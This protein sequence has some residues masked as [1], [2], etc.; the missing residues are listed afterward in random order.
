ML[1]F[2]LRNLTTLILLLISVCTVSAFATPTAVDPSLISKLE[3]SDYQTQFDVVVLLHPLPD[4]K[5]LENL[6][7]GVERNQ[8]SSIVWN[9]LIEQTS[10]SQ[11]GFN[12]ALSG[13]ATSA[14]IPLAK[15]IYICNGVQLQVSKAELL[16]I[17]TMDVVRVCIDD[18]PR[19]IENESPTTTDF[20]EDE[21]DDISWHISHIQAPFIW[22][23]GY[24]GQGVLVAVFD[25]GVN[26]NHLD[27]RDHVWDGG[28]EYPNHGY[29]FYD[30][31][32][33]PMDSAGHGTAAA[34]IVAGDGSAGTTTGVA[35]DATIM[36][37]KV[38][39]SLNVG[40]VGDTWRA[41]DFVVEHGVDIVQMSLGWGDPGL[42]DRP[43]WRHNYNVLNAA[44]IVNVKS[45][46]NRRG[47]RE[48]PDAISVP[49]GVPSPWRHPDEIEAGERSGLITVGSLNQENN[50][51]ASSSPG[52]VT[53][54]DVEGYQDFLLGDGH[55]G[56]IKPDLAAPGA[57]GTSLRHSNDSLYGGFSHTS[58]AAPHV[59]GVV[60][61]MLSKDPNLLPVQVDSLL[62]CSAQDLGEPGKD[63]DYGAG[64]V[65]ADLAVDAIDV[66]MGRVKGHVSGNFNEPVQ[67]VTV[68]ALERPR[69]HNHT[70][71]TGYFEF[72]LQPGE[73]TI[74]VRF[75]QFELQRQ[76]SVQIVEN[77]TTVID[78]VI[79]TLDVPQINTPTQ[80]I[81]EE[82]AIRSV[83]PNP[84]NSTVTIQYEIPETATISMQLYSIEGRLVDTL[85][86]SE[87]HIAGKYSI[88][89]ENSSL[90]SGIYLLIM[91]T[92]SGQKMSQ[93]LLYLK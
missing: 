70:D 1:N 57:N 38:R 79:N 44:G 13:I 71:S 46:G 25:T 80:L 41:Q 68:M 14:T 47:V 3:N 42:Y 29:N 59:S 23:D 84:F 54:Q 55:V 91:S 9:T 43:V 30:D 49:G 62:Q 48:P 39:R 8:R 63:N 31:S 16:E 50:F 4:V 7:K 92:D 89:Y 51:L 18:S 10:N 73:Y 19:T 75:Q 87:L 90:S 88:N 81:P 77:D 32:F 76:D 86:S 72:D 11:T 35:P 61:L 85:E 34:G 67:N 6:V 66:P 53:W 21:L 56:L 74:V 15:P 78:F 45:A 12:E 27:L 20:P 17:L 24:R 37:V 5:A 40:E 65:R 83:F 69:R 60:A 64:L 22:E 36:A 58:M 2:N 33:D 82:F 93:K 26:Y 28:E 52:P